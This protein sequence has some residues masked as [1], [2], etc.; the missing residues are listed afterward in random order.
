MGPAVLL[1]ISNKV[2][3]VLLIVILFLNCFALLISEAQPLPDEEVQALRNIATKL[4]NNYWNV[5]SSS[6]SGGVGLNVTLDYGGLSN[7]TCN[8]SNTV[9]HITNIQL[10]ALNLTGV[11]PEE[12]VDLPYLQEID[13]TRNYLNGSLPSRWARIPLVIISLLGNRISGSIPKEIGNIATLEQ[14]VLED[15]QLEGNLPPELGNL[16]RLKRFIVSANN[17]TGII[18]E[19]YGNLTSLEIFMIDGNGISGKIP[20]FIGNWTRLTRLDMQGTSLE[21]PVPP[22]ISLLQNLNA[23]RVSDLD[24]SNMSFPFPDLRNLTNINE[25]VLR[26]CSVTGPIPEYIGKLMPKLKTLDLSFNRLTGQIPDFES[27]ANL[28]FLFLTNN[29]LTGEVPGWLFTKDKIKIDLSYNNFTGYASQPSCAQQTTVKTIASYS[30]SEDNSVA[31]CLKKDLPC[32]GKPKYHSLFINCGGPLMNFDGEEYADD[33]VPRVEGASYFYPT[34]RWASSTTGFY[35]NRNISQYLTTNSSVLK[36]TDPSIYMTARIAPISLRYYG[37]CLRSGSYTVRLHFAEITFTEDQTF[38]SLGRRIFDVSIQGVICLKDFNIAEEAKGVGKNITKEFNNV[39]VN[40]STLEIHLYWSGKGTAAIPSRGVYGPLISA[41][42]VTPNFDTN[43]GLS[44][45]VIVGIVAASCVLVAIILVILWVKGCFGGKDLDD[46]ALELQTGHFSLRQIK[47]ATGNFDSANKIGE[48]GFGPVYKGTLSDGKVIAVKQLSSKSKQGNREFVN[49]IGMISALQHPNLV[50][51]YG[52]CIEGNQLLLI[53]EYMENNSL[54]RALFGHEDQRM[55]LNWR[56][57]HKI[58]LGI[59]Q[60]LAYLHEES[61]LKI[62][63][64]DIKATNV[65]LDKDLNAKISDFGLAKLDEEEN[66]H[67]STR[68][69]GTIGYMAPEYAMRGYLTDKADVYSFGVV[70]LEIVSGTSNTNYRPREE[71][72]YLLDWAYVL[73][74]QGNLLELVDPILGSNYSTEEALR[75]LNLA[76]LCT[77]PSPPLRPAMSAVVSMLEGKIAVKAP[78]VKRSNTNEDLRF[79]AFEKLSKENQTPFS[80]TSQERDLYPQE[81][82]VQ[83]SQST[84]GPWT[85]SS[86][87]IHSDEANRGNPSESKLVQ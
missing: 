36:M 8:C 48:G 35:L 9:C 38:S 18:P 52:C 50:K 54:A 67:I 10:K 63:H 4:K 37:L 42:S 43:T 81:S 60:G 32:S 83:S 40:G 86:T 61:R 29:L 73:Q 51:L 41:I 64:R 2:S 82:H 87:S 30:S 72:I 6:C 11:L 25:L 56:S 21:G 20:Y 76:L 16:S 39:T 34:D 53:Y 75:M 74:E 22:N 19:T 85:D 79:K 3:W 1:A 55:N 33:S 58:C 57:R 68:I 70:A 26:N 77:N 46:K 5:S 14:L 24:G 65:L 78:I 13:L 27:S 31:W 66:T 49:E 45:G 71:F 47:A 23:L 59:A 69:A 7:I 84:V 62:V 80:S 12:F 28:Q 44:V 15:N 17:F